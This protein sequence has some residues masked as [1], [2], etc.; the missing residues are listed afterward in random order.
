M[1]TCDFFA[2]VPL[3]VLQV[4]FPNS[5]CTWLAGQFLDTQS[6]VP[7]SSNAS[8]LALF[9]LNALRVLL[10]A[11][12]LLSCCSLLSSPYLVAGPPKRASGRP[13]WPGT[14]QIP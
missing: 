2:H 8:Y 6:E 10:P 13:S 5:K 9:C 1:W 3:H 4:G 11:F 14:W 7:G 12:N